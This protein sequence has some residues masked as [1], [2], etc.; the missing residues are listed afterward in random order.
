MAKKHRSIE[1]ELLRHIRDEYLSKTSREEIASDTNLFE[2]GTV[3][4]AGLLSFISFIENKYGISVPDEDLLPE[5]F[6]CVA[7]IA[8][9]IR[10]RTSCVAK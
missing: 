7:R 6:V 5:N 9:Y 2:T 1:E 3:D 8:D 10:T 4:S